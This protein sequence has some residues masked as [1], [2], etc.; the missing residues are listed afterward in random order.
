MRKVILLLSAGF[1]FCLSTSFSPKETPSGIPWKVKKYVSTYNYLA[2]QVKQAYGIPKAIIFAVAGLESHWGTSELARNSNNHFGI[3]SYNWEGPVYCKKTWEYMAA[4][5]FFR[6]EDCFRQYRLIKEGYQDFGKH[7]Q[8]DRYR[9]LFWYSKI[10][11]T[12]WAYELQKAGYA[13]DPQY[14][15]KLIRLI[16]DYE[17]HR[18]D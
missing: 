4:A 7:L 10:D 11:Y 5:G 15:E 9:K 2:N 12:N 16:E 6:I 1:F 17:L 18:L 3:K 14:A 8:K 13:T